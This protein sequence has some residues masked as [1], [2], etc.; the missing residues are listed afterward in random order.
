[1][2]NVS[3]PR[4][5]FTLI[6]LLVVIAI[7]A[8]LIALLLPAVQAAREAARRSQCVNNL[9]QLGL[10]VHNYA[11]KNN[12]F[13]LKDMYPNASNYSC[14]WSSSW[15]LAVLPGL[16]QQAMF[17]AF[18]FVFTV[19]GANWDT[20][21]T[22]GNGFKNSTVGRAQIATLL[23][24]SENLAV[25]PDMTNGGMGT[26]NYYGNAGG[27]GVISTHSGTIVPNHSGIA[28]T[29][30]SGYGAGGPVTFAAVVDGTS[31]TALFS[32]KL[33]GV[34][35]SG[36]AFTAGSINAK[37]GLFPQPAAIAHDTGDP[38]NALSFINKCKS[39][40]ASTAS[41]S[42]YSGLSWTSAYPPYTVM[43]A[44]THFGAPNSLACA[45]DNAVWGGPS[46]SLP[47]TSN[48]SGGV[49]V[50]FADGSVKFIKDSVNLQTW[51]ALGTKYGGEV[52]SAD[53]Y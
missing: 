10:A 7:I 4:R 6:E 53:A 8:V 29:I 14:G 16:E 25:H 15:P 40:P 51:W 1:M 18:N 20:G 12:C 30:G 43:N 11:D 2:Q 52:V 36:P 34:G 21:C 50:G 5:G 24:P 46:A 39:T 41:A 45:N 37:R 48:H 26:M 13:P 28:T 23:C 27:P 31:N 9:K 19:Q 47:P 44:Y 38:A 22:N 3:R 32:E 35:P 42:S 49:N 33:Y 17:D